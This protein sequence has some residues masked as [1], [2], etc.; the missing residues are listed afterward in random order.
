MLDLSKMAYLIF[1]LLFLGSLAIFWLIFNF[2]PLIKL[3]ITY[4]TCKFSRQFMYCRNIPI[5]ITKEFHFKMKD[6]VYTMNFFGKHIAKSNYSLLVVSDEES[7]DVTAKILRFAGPYG[8]FFGLDTTP[9][10]LGY[11]KLYINA[12]EVDENEL[13]P[14]LKQF[15]D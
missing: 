2:Y 3:M 8:N 14:D 7:S 6:D 4:Y 1:G 9:K 12:I 5:K 11:K 13:I 15:R 10:D